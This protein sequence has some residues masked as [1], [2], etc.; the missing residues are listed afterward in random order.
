M[1]YT[2]EEIEDIFKDGLTAILEKENKD[3]RIV[4]EKTDVHKINSEG[5]FIE[6]ELDLNK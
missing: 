1:G 2:E 3:K 6:D 5:I 4:E